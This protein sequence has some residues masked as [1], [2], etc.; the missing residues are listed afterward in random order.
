MDWLC[1]CSYIEYA[2]SRSKVLPLNQLLFR[3][4]SWHLALRRRSTRVRDSANE[5]ALGGQRISL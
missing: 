4:P 2:Q 3:T 5:H 1:L